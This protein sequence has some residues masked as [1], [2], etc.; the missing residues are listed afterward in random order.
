M[1]LTADEVRII[2][3]LIATSDWAELLH[4]QLRAASVTG[5]EWTGG[6]HLLGEVSGCRPGL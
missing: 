5:R 1:D 3:T 4:A 2:Q 6:R